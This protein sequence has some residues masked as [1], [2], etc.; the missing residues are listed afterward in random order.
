[1]A[2]VH[3]LAFIS[4]DFHL[5]VH[6]ASLSHWSFFQCL[7]QT[8]LHNYVNILLLKG[9]KLSGKT[10]AC[11]AFVRRISSEVYRPVI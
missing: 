2:S 3:H 1:M 5:P 4:I 11:S 8:S 7:P 9:P 10:T 6:V